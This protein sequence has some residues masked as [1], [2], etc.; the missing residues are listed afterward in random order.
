MKT[1]FLLLCLFFLTQQ[2]QVRDLTIEDRI[3]INHKKQTFI[4]LQD[5]SSYI[6]THEVT[7]GEWKE[8][9]KDSQY[10]WDFKTPFPQTDIHPVVGINLIDAT[11]Y[12]EWFSKKSIFERTITPY[13]IYRL[14]NQ[15]EWGIA[16]QL[17]EYIVD[18]PSMDQRTSDEAMFPWGK[19]WPPVENAANLSAR[20][21]PDYKDAYEFTAPVGSF[22]PNSIGLFDI[23]GN[24]WEW[25]LEENNTGQQTAFL[26][27][28]SW[29][30]FQKATLLSKYKYTINLQSRYPTVGFRICLVDKKLAQLLAKTPKKIDASI[31][32][33]TDSFLKKDS[34]I[35]NQVNQTASD[36][37]AS[38]KFDPT[39]PTNDFSTK[40][41]I[42]DEAKALSEQFLNKNKPST[43]ALASTQLAVVTSPAQKNQPY[44]NSLGLQFTPHTQLTNQLIG[45]TEV[46]FQDIELWYKSIGK[47]WK[48]KPTLPSK[49][50]FAVA[51]ISWNEANEFCTWLTQLEITKKFISPQFKYR[52]LKDKEWSLIVELNESPGLPINNH[53]VVKNHFPWSPS[54]Q[55]PPATNQENLDAQKIPSYRDSSSYYSSAQAELP[56]INNLYGLGGNVSEWCLDDW[57]ANE[58]V[59]R[60]GS[61]LSSNKEELLSSYRNHL[62]ADS[63]RPNIGFR[64]LLDLE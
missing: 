57:D 9:L 58:K 60:G 31:T 19:E 7:V 63:F 21:I 46:R 22:K 62:P 37:I 10:P 34:T 35:D 55:F 39:A 5:T 28:G 3:F 45:T 16:N 32:D 6:C 50:D 1:L 8:F 47:E 40:Q 30:Y 11:S 15:K 54:N 48:N 26:R 59:I 53:L 27:G 4:Q 52:L 13:Q 20:D 41:V 17:N 2:A 51:N 44:T 64:I 14:P 33:T 42:N 18:S 12:C 29:A 61:W 56:S 25:N 24:V 43:E 36:L 23:S 38:K 49:P